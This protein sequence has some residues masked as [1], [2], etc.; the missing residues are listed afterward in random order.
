MSDLRSIR[1]GNADPKS[2]ERDEFTMQHCLVTQQTNKVLRSGKE[3]QR[4]LR[5]L[6]QSLLNCE[7]CS[8]YE[9]CELREQFNLQV[10]IVIADINEEWGW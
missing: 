8:I 7:T 2:L 4:A 9:E 5:H 10:D 1:P 6:R 3:T